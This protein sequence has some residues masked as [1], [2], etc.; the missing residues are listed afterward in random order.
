[1]ALLDEAV[2]VLEASGARLEHARAVVDRGALLRRLGQRKA[3]TAALREGMELADRCGA[4]AL[5]ESAARRSCG[6]PARARGGS[7]RA[8][9][10][11]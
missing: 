4:T 9:A 1:M 10:S 6:S 3:A 2:A 8:G 5:V 11:R 7:R